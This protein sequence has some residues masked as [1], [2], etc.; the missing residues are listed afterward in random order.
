MG[1][2]TDC[3]DGLRVFNQA[4]PGVFDGGYAFTECEV[5][6]ATGQ[7]APMG[8]GY[9]LALLPTGEY[10]VEVVP[11]P[12]YEVVRSQDKNVDFGD[13]Y[14]PAPNALPPACVGAPYTVPDY[15]T[16]FPPVPGEYDGVPAPLAGTSLNHCD[17][18]QV[19]VNEGQNTAADFFL[20]T[21]V[22]V[23]AHIIGMILD[24][25]AN[26]F[27]PNS[28]QFG[29]KYAPPWVPVAI[30]DWTGREITRV[31]SDQYGRYNVLVPSTYTANLPQPSGMGPNMLN[32]CMNARTL[33]DGT[34]DPYYDPQYSEFCYVLQYMPGVATYLDTPVVPVAAHAGPD[35]L[36]VDCELPDGTPRIKQVTVNNPVGGGPYVTSVTERIRID[37]VGRVRVPNPDYC[38]GPPIAVGCPEPYNMDRTILRDYGFGRGGSVKLNGVNLQVVSWNSAYI[39]AVPPTSGGAL[40]AQKGQVVVTR[41]D[42]GRSSVTGI[43][44][45]VGTH[46]ACGNP[47]CV[48]AVSN[49]Q[50]IQEALD[51]AAPNELIL[52]GPGRYSEMLMISQPVQLQGWG[53]NTTVIDA[54]AIPPSKLADW[55]TKALEL[56]NSGAVDLLP[57]QEAAAPTLFGPGTLATEE[58]AGVIVFGRPGLYSAA[59]NVRIDGFTITG[60]DN[61]GGV[62]ANGYT[63]Y[64]EISNNRI[65]NNAGLFGGGIRLGTRSC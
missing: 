14:V 35:E 42:N 28:P 45:H 20:F 47:N 50:S 65:V 38:P 23:A 24:D 43:T 7:C 8:S 63:P 12:H 61:G 56:V 5:D 34:Q 16:L 3:Y 57:G 15:L 52:V 53:E 36:P 51:A 18:K 17:R 11:P 2:A 10:V 6:P 33:P 48:R 31:Y 39:I 9:P 49:G 27:D 22:P 32:A 44:V 58:G 26:E 21:E 60:A 64:L 59:Q 19:F 30:R 54:L 1:E 4:R 41:S 29:E 62:I 40:V 46:T 13:S 37:A 25:T 55:R